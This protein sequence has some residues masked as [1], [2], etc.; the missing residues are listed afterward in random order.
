[1]NNKKIMLGFIALLVVIGTVVVVHK[2]PQGDV[3]C[4]KEAKICPDGSSVGRTRPLCE[5]AVCPPLKVEATSTP[6]SAT[7]TQVNKI[8]VKQKG[9]LTGSMT[10]GP[11]CPV[12][13]IDNPCEPSSEMYASRKVFVY[14]SN[15]T[16]LITTLTPDSK[17]NFSV[18]LSPGNYYIDMV[19]QGIGTIRGVPMMV[20]IVS[21]KTFTLSI[22]VDTGIR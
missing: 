12:E 15:K 13:R 5:F 4:T 9:M 16:V 3:V 11:I 20:T 8:L 7:T 22:D 17:G 14:A 6:I 19:H 10:I 21:G 2:T 1:M 18:S